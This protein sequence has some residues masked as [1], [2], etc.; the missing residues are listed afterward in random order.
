MYCEVAALLSTKDTKI[1]SDLLSKAVYV[2]SCIKESLRLNPVSIGVGR[3]SQKDFILRG[4]LIPKGVST[5]V[6][7]INIFNGEKIIIN[8][9]YDYNSFRQ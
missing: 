7:F 4:Y 9:K 6:L 3:L 8:I 5:L 2:R 1:T